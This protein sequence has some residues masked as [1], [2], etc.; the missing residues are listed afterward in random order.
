[1][2]QDMSFW[3]QVESSKQNISNELLDDVSN[4]TV[5]DVRF[6]APIAFMALGASAII[7]KKFFKNHKPAQQ[8]TLAA[9]VKSKTGGKYYDRAAG[10]VQ[11]L[12]LNAHNIT[13]VRV[14]DITKFDFSK[15]K[16][17]KE[18]FDI[19]KEEPIPWWKKDYIRDREYTITMG[20]RL[21]HITR[22]HLTD[23]RLHSN[24]KAAF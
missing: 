20:K 18:C 24:R 16:P 3:T 15:V 9:D 5:F 14:D 22:S 6:A 12:N 10:K 7:Y 2:Y 4:K 13:N 19:L 8:V 21:S 1:M 23:L 11:S 17:Y